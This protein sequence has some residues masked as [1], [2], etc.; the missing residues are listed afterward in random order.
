MAKTRLLVIAC[1]FVVA[2]LVIAG[3]LI[4]VSLLR[5]GG[6]EILARAR[7]L[8]G[9]TFR[10]DIVDRNGELLATSLSTSSLYANARKVLDAREA[11][12]KLIQ[13]LPELN[14]KEITQRLQ[15]GKG[16]VWLVRHLTPQK[17]AEIIRLGIPGIY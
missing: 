14:H 1:A 17:Q 7:A 13:V 8:K 4:D 2:F 11:A 12:D 6:E 5:G 15:S 10:A 9:I 16:F 3:R